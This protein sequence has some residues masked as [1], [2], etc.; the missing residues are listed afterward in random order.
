MVSMGEDG[1]DNPPPPEGDTLSPAEIE[2][3]AV[4]IDAWQTDFGDWRKSDCANAAKASVAFLRI[5]LAL[6]SDGSTQMALSALGQARASCERAG[7]L[8]ETYEGPDA[9]RFR[10]EIIELD[11]Q[12]RLAWERIEP[13]LK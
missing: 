5:C 11:N 7:Q 8:L 9:E 12:L 2:L 1:T 10:D 13:E 3:A 4:A 6:L